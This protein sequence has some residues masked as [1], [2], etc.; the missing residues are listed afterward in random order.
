MSGCLL[1]VNCPLCGTITAA[2][3]NSMCAPLSQSHLEF[4]P[5]ASLPQSFRKTRS[6]L[7]SVGRVGSQDNLAPVVVTNQ[8]A[9]SWCGPTE[10]LY[11]ELRASATKFFNFRRH[12][13]KS[14]LYKGAEISS[15][16]SMP[17]F[18]RK[19]RVTPFLVLRSGRA[20][21]RERHSRGPWQP[22]RVPRE[23]VLCTCVPTL[24]C[25]LWQFWWERGGEHLNE[26]EPRR[27]RCG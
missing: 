3:E 10:P 12:V 15:N 17:I 1:F 2:P 26:P 7:H 5:I 13:G 23:H 14:S 11:V 9:I 25:K 8:S 19:A 22:C 4:H 18:T 6:Y 20:G 24:T 16:E 27:Q 21:V